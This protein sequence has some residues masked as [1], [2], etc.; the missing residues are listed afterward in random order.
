MQC[1]IAMQVGQP[2]ETDLQRFGHHSAAALHTV[3]DEALVAAAGDVVTFVFSNQVAGRADLGAPGGP[4]KAG[5]SGG[6]GA[7]QAEAGKKSACHSSSSSRGLQNNS[8][9]SSNRGLQVSGS[10]PATAAG[11]PQVQQLQPPPLLHSAAQQQPQPRHVLGDSSAQQL[12]CPPKGAPHQ[13]GDNAPAKLTQ[14]PQQAAA[15]SGMVALT[16][17]PHVSQQ[18]QQPPKR[19]RIVF[20]SCRP[21]AP[22]VLPPSAS[23]AVHVQAGAPVQ[24]DNW[25]GSSD[26]DFV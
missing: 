7:L 13:D 10:A 25:D 24:S 20:P 5:V 17:L 15:V 8:G 2:S 12:N 4:T 9:S 21:P 22:S 23:V 1:I 16:G 19:Q 3:P 26:E 6:G 11:L 18:R 14:T